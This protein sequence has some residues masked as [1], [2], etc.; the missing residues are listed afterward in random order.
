MYPRVAGVIA[1]S[2]PVRSREWP[3]VALVNVLAATTGRETRGA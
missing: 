2:N 3:K 1:F